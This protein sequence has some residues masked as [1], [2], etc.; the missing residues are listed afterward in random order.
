MSIR[1]R[2]SK[3]AK[4]GYVYEV[5]FPYKQNGITERYSKSGFKTK[6]EAQEHEALTIASL[7]ENGSIKKEINKTLNEVFSEFVEIGSTNYQINTITTM[8][9]NYEAHVKNKLG[10][11]PINKIDYALLQKYF[12]SRADSSIGVNKNVKKVINCAMNYAIKANYI[13]INP[14]SLVDISGIDK[15]KDKD[16]I[17]LNTE[18]DTIIEELNKTNDFT[19]QAYAIA[20]QIGRYTGLRISEVFALE[21]SDID[22]END[23]ID[24]NKKLIYQ[25]LKKDQLYYTNQMK[26]KSSKAV[27][28]LAN[29][30]KNILVPWFNKNPYDKAVC[31]IEGNYIHPSC[32]N[33]QVKKICMRFNIYF[34]FHMLRHTFATTLATNNV[35]IKT[36]Q[37]LMR[38][39]N[40]NT[41]MNI[42]THIND[43]VKKKAINDVF[44]IKSVEKVSKTKQEFSK[45]S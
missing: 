18:I 28:P 26:S 6:K 10:Q 45:L 42:Y 12:N 37:E 39:S 21:K 27:I 22:F 30:L 4:N 44:N 16:K 32:F 40:F 35:D 19:Y 20:I 1:K 24:V 29:I 9:K 23:T 33:L 38:H 2:P 5:Y 8:R 25:N 7:K 15:T 14:I 3:K 34:H 36:T 17:L 11:L 43:T 31:D 41:T 13:T